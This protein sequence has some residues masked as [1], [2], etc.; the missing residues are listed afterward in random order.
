MD[1]SPDEILDERSLGHIRSLKPY[2][3]EG[4]K[5]P[6]PACL[7]AAKKLACIIWYDLQRCTVDLVL[8][9]I[10]LLLIFG[11]GGYWG[12]RRGHW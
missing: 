2:R 12:R 5:E 6:L 7:F 10:V 8:I 11:G 9:L 4:T 1:A 3:G